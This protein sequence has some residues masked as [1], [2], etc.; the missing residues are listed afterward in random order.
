[1]SA[2]TSITENR[3]ARGAPT[4]SDSNF[5]ATN[6]NSGTGLQSNCIQ[7]GVR[8]TQFNAHTQTFFNTTQALPEEE[9]I[10]QYL[11]ALL[12]IRPEDHRAALVST[13]GQRVA[14]T[15]EWIKDDAEYQALLSGESRLL[16]IQGGPGKGKTMLSAFLTQEF[17]KTENVVYFFCRADDETYRTATYVLR[18]LIWQLA[19]QQPATAHHLT[20][21]LYP[22]DQKPAVLTSRETLWSI[23]VKITSDPNFIRTFCLLDGLDECDDE[24]QRW[25]AMMFIQHCET[26]EGAPDMSCMRVIIASRPG[27]LALR[28]SKQIVLDPDNDDQISHDIEVFVKFRV[29]ELSN[30]LGNLSDN[31]RA[32]FEADMQNELLSRANGTFLWVRFA[33]EELIRKRTRLQMKDAIQEL[34][35]GLPA[36]YD[37]MLHQ[38][39]SRYRLICS[40][41]LRWVAFAARPLSVDE[42]ETITSFRL[43]GFVAGEHYIL[44]QLAICGAFLTISDDTVS[45]VHE[46]ARE[47]LSHSL[48]PGASKDSHSQPSMIHLEMA[49]TCLAYMEQ[50][51]RKPT[52]QDDLV[53]HVAHPGRS[54]LSC[55]TSDNESERFSDYATL[56]WL[57]HAR[58]SGD[59]FRH[60]VSASPLFFAEWSGMRDRWWSKFLGYRILQSRYYVLFTNHD[61]S[62]LHMAC[63]LGITS[64]VTELLGS[65]LGFHV[66]KRRNRPHDKLGLSPLMYAVRGGHTSIVEQLLR[67]HVKIGAQDINGQTALHHAV[68]YQKVAIA[69]V[70]LKHR[71]DADAKDRNGESVLHVA[72]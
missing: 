28:T 20:Q 40:K 13:K 57:E 12:T 34:P 38:I 23:L 2:R 18:S 55:T 69:Q 42:L 41:I 3:M 39:D 27:V 1:M 21:Y 51:Y 66:G 6:I 5:E 61:T 63:Y 4:H 25:L 22:P 43:A 7:T 50:D 26:H 35:I 70:L 52:P 44:D 53:T 33:M 46:S 9:K 62:A 29:R 49:T 10:V 36:I 60:L 67:N 15:C 11:N 8:N 56:H 14:G 32:A 59:S 68:E 58:Q 72:A 16:W 30:Q 64:W 65:K 54:V 45:L 17:E 48:D 24:S 71:A 31:T 47:Y 19:V 37:R